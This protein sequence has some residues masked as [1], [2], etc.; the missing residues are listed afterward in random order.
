MDEFIAEYLAAENER[1]T[2]F[3]AKVQIEIE[4][5]RRELA[6]PHTE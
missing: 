4:D 1:I 6:G 2:E 3:N 5:A